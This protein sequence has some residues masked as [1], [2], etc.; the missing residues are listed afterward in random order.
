M[1]ARAD[2][3]AAGGAAYMTLPY[4]NIEAKIL[5][6]HLPKKPPRPRWWKEV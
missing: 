2:T 1:M 4:S 5:I 3:L 6:A